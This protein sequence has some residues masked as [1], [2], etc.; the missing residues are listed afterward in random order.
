[1]SDFQFWIA[2]LMAFFS[3]YKYITTGEVEWLILVWMMNI[4]INLGNKDE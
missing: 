3:I 4:Y 2:W 1:M